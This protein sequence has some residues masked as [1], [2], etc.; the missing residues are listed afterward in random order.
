M[1]SVVDGVASSCLKCMLLGR[2]VG[3]NIVG[4]VDENYVSWTRLL[5]SFESAVL[6]E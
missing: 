5:R 6:S 4:F 1:A 2:E 3:V